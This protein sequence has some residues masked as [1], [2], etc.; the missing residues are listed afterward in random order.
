[1]IWVRKDITVHV[2]QIMTPFVIYILAEEL[3]FSGILAVV[4]AGVVHA[5]ERERSESRTLELQKVSDNTWSVIL[6]ILNGLVFVLLGLQVPDASRVVLED[7]T[8]GNGAVIAYIFAI[9]LVL[10]A[11]RFVWLTLFWKKIKPLMT[12]KESD[13]PKFRAITTLTVSGVRG[14]VTLAGA[15]SIPYVISGGSPFLRGI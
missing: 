5:I 11:L 6:Y 8:F 13:L 1:M 4:A 12:F 9:T 2:I 3:G 14:A 15:F 7:P 10:L